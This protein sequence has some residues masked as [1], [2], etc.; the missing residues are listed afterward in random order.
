MVVLSIGE[1]TVDL[2]LFC[3][4]DDETNVFLMQEFLLD[5]VQIL[6]HSYFLI[7]RFLPTKINRER[8]RLQKEIYGTI[9]DI[10]KKCSMSEG[11]SM[12]HTLVDGAKHGELGP[13]T[14]QEFVVDNCKELCV[15]SMFIPGTTA[16]WG[17]MLL[18]LH[19]K[20]QD[21]ACAEVLEVCG[22]H[23]P[24]AEMLGKMLVVCPS[25]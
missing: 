11:K 9:L 5:G 18:A 13:S 17:L 12:I 14:P 21:R 6:K 16:I 19:P 10:T 15:V 7:F 23:I 8:W 3:S 24:D 20:W 2:Q 1:I 22:G 4:N 25:L